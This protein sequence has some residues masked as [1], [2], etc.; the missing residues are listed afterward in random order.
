MNEKKNVERG[1]LLKKAIPVWSMMNSL[2]FHFLL[3]FFHL[4]THNHTRRNFILNQATSYYMHNYLYFY[5][6]I[7][8][9]RKKISF[10]YSSNEYLIPILQLS[11]LKRKPC[12]QEILSF[13]F[14]SYF[15]FKL[16][17]AFLLHVFHFFEHFEHWRRNSSGIT[18]W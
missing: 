4:V 1:I 16:L 9:W 6:C 17:P 7:I 10:L 14:S 15:R 13:F 18:S 5:M 12:C 2:A 11:P 8:W 3:W